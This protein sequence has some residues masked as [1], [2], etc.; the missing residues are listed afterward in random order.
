MKARDLLQSLMLINPEVEVCIA[1]P[2]GG[3]K[4]ALHPI[5]KTQILTQPQPLVALFAVP[6]QAAPAPVE[7]KPEPAAKVTP[8][9]KKKGK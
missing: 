1:L 5:S 3:G 2:I 6:P 9:K 8:I 7:K 4:A